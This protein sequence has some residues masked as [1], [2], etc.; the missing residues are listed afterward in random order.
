[1]ILEGVV[2]TQDREGRLNVA[3]MGPIVEGDFESLI[4]RPF[5]GS[6]MVDEL[7]T[8]KCPT[9]MPVGSWKPSF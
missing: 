7:D 5:K 1:M 9:F 4:L 3:P 8:I 6:T 2:T